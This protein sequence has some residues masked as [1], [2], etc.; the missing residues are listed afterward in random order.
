MDITAVF[1]NSEYEHHMMAW[2]SLA[3]DE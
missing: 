2:N 1:G 3:A